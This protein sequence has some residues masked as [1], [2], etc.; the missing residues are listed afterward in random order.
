MIKLNIIYHSELPGV[1]RLALFSH[2][3]YEVLEWLHDA[4]ALC[5]LVVGEAAGHDDHSRQHDAKVQLDTQT[6]IQTLIP[7]HLCL[8][9][10]YSTLFITTGWPMNTHTFHFKTCECISGRHTKAYGNEWYFKICVDT[11]AKCS[12]LLYWNRQTDRQTD[13]QSHRCK[14]KPYETVKLSDN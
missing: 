12:R 4:W 3:R 10:A 13:G 14:W 7:A 6:H 8:T 11:S 5:L 1:I 2:L 9:P